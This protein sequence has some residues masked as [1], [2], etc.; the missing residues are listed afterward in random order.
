M[1]DSVIADIDFI[2]AMAIAELKNPVRFSTIPS[3]DMFRYREHQFRRHRHG[4][5]LMSNEVLLAQQKQLECDITLANDH[6]YQLKTRNEVR[7]IQLE[8]K[9]ISFLH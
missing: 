1:L 3:T 5:Q 6:I 9:S 7:A 2:S 4:K 8:K